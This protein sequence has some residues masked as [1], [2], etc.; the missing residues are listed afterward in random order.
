MLIVEVK[1]ENI[2]IEWQNFTES[3]Y[4]EKESALSYLSSL[5]FTQKFGLNCFNKFDE[6]LT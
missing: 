2:E 6:L 5:D 1:R 4:Y 3:N